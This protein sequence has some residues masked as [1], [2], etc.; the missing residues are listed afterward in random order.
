MNKAELLTNDPKKQLI[1]SNI[2][3]FPDGSGYESL[4]FVHSEG[5]Q[6]ETLFFFSIYGFKMFC[7]D[8]ELMSEKLKGTAKL[9]T[10]YEKD[11]IS[12]EI[13]KL[14]QVFVSGGFYRYGIRQ[15]L[16]FE[17]QTDQTCL[18]LFYLQLKGYF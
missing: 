5:F 18:K 17:F 2:N 1:L 10:D 3:K 9:A 12:F 14:G 4:V 16:E 7:K 11:N 15:C 13:N 8:L 6:V